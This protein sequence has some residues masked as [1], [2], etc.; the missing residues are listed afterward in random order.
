MCT[1]SIISTGEPGFR[2]VTNRDVERA[3]PAGIAPAWR[4]VAG[5]RAVW[6]TDAQAGGTWVGATDR[7]LVLCLLN[8]N[9]EPAPDLS[10][11]GALKSRGTIIPGLVGE[12]D[13]AGAMTRL[14][15]MELS[16]FAPFRLLACDMDGDVARV[17]EADWDRRSLTRRDHVAP[18]CFVSSGL[19]DSKVRV[20]LP[21]FDRSVREYGPDAQDAFHHHVWPDRPELSV[22]MS[23]GDARTVSITTVEVGLSGGRPRVAMSYEPVGVGASLAPT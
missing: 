13:A 23:R 6:P 11:L 20:R 1:V 3:R 15:S 19:G 14:A 16:T 9:M 21:L 10:G 5:G 8:K 18:T 17:L 7:G 12:P 22:L 4:S 2:L